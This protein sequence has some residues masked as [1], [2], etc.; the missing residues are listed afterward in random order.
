MMGAY[1]DS[2]L[3]WRDIAWL[4]RHTK[5]PIVLKGVQTAQDAMLAAQYGC[6]G[7]VLSNHGGRNLDTSPAS[8]LV[9]L[10]LHKT[11]PTVFGKVEILIDGG[12]RRGTDILKALCLG[13]TAVGL[14]RPY[15]YA[16]NYGQDGVRHMTDILADELRVSMQMVGIT[17]LEDAHPGLVNTAEI[18]YLVPAREGHPYARPVRRGGM[19]ARL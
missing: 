13:A 10:E 5:L 12:I 17:R 16:L 9:L 11:C 1:I 8:L 19:W 3:N 14:G 7:I 6:E 2:S 18:D 15:L 4:R